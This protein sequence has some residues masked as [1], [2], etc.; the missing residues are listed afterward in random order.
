MKN[1]EHEIMAIFF[2]LN[3]CALQLLLKAEMHFFPARSVI[4]DRSF[5]SLYVRAIIKF[6]IYCDY[7]RF[8]LP[9]VKM[10]TVL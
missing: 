6:Q 8:L 7:C 2:H 9:V 5:L 1:I 10:Q 3:R 4:V